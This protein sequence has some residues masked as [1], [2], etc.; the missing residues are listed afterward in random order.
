M[1][2]RTCE[3]CGA[4][5]MVYPAALRKSPN[6]GRYCS[7]PCRGGAMRGAANPHWNGGRSV[8]PNGYVQTVANG[9]RDFE[10]VHIVE[11]AVG[12]RLP[13]G[14]RI[15]HVD[16]D[17]SNNVG[18]NLVVCQDDAYHQ[19]L[20]VR[21]RVVA[22]GG[23]PNTDKLCSRCKIPKPFGAFYRDSSFTDGRCKYC[24]PCYVL[25]QQVAR[26]RRSEASIASPER[27]SHG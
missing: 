10:H 23:N 15:H 6:G 12:R 13:L 1:L 17:R 21:A 11:R 2:D 25:R 19:L 14:A 20:H 26:R 7:K 18:R 22:A 3:T 5:F 16:G 9:R 8:K 24:K 27:G 4:A